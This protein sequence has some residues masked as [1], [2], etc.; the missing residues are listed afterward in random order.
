MF[1]GLIYIGLRA[2]LS[3]VGEQGIAPI[4]SRTSNPTDII[5]LFLR[6]LLA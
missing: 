4:S 1:G 2:W 6:L 3:F 5:S